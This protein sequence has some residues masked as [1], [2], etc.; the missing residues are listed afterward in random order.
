MA[1][2]PPGRS[3]WAIR[4]MSFTLVGSSEMVHKLR[5]GNQ[6][7][8]VGPQVSAEHVTGA[9]GRYDLPHPFFFQDQ[10]GRLN[11][12]RKI[13]NRRLKLRVAAA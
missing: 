4:S 13:E 12:R 3:E 2:I 10:A 9:V 6:V 8:P 11:R 1:T 5:T 7:P